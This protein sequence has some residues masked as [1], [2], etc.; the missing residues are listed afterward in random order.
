LVFNAPTRGLVGLRSEI[1]N[2]TKGTGVIQTTFIGYSEYRGSLKKNLKGA[3]L[4]MA[5]GNCSGYALEDI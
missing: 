2:D 4:S 3:I 5:S 1:L